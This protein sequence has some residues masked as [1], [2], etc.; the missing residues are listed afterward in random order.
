MSTQWVLSL[1]FAQ[2]E[3]RELKE[4][5]MMYESAS[6]LGALP[7]GPLGGST[8]PPLDDSYVQLGIKKPQLLRTPESHG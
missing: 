5:V 1:V 6:Q 2:S 4:E 8:V 3:I 7:G